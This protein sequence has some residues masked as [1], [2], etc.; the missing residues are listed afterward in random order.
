MKTRE[1]CISV[2]RTAGDCCSKVAFFASLLILKVLMNLSDSRREE[3]A[4]EEPGGFF[5]RYRSAV[6]E[7]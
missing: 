4:G 7:F 5:E 2:L 1:E 6:E 3:Q